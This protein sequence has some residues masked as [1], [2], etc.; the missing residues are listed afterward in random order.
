M[1]ALPAP[2]TATQALSTSSIVEISSS[3]VYVGTRT[4]P[5]TAGHYELVWSLD[6]TLSPDQVATD[7][8]YVGATLDSIST[9]M[10]EGG[11]VVTIVQPV[12]ESGNI[13]IYQGD[14]YK[15]VDGRA[16][17]WTS[18]TW[19]VVTGSTAIV[20]FADQSGAVT[21]IAA[22]VTSSSAISLQL[23]ATQTTAIK[24]GTYALKT[25]LSNGDII[26][27]A[28]GKVIASARP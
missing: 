11:A 6:G 5:A 16:L 21:G 4:S 12:G 18:S 28:T 3:G 22:S 25:T 8:L 14:D 20:D 17:Q 24:S 23:T 13:A 27:L 26:T 15:T 10:G 9:L 19:P 1:E 2:R 7:D